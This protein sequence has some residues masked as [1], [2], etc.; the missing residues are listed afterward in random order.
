MSVCTAVLNGEVLR[1][2]STL[3]PT[4]TP[5]PRLGLETRFP[6]PLIFVDLRIGARDCVCR[7][8]A[9][10]YVCLRWGRGRGGEGFCWGCGR[11]MF[12]FWTVC[13]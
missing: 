6:L 11:G 9:W 1:R 3:S 8:Y 7:V 12:V 10:L 2:S 5:L 4:H 13:D